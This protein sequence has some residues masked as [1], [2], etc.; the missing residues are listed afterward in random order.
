MADKERLLQDFLELVQIDSPSGQ[1]RQIADV[2]KNKLAALGF[3]VE[4]DNAGGQIG[5]TAGNIIARLPGTGRGPM[6]MLSAHMD[7]VEPGR[8]VKPVIKD[9]VITSQGDTVL[10]GDDKGGIAV[11]LEAVRIIQEKNISHGGLEVIFTVWEEGGLKGSKALDYSKIKSKMG[12]VLDADGEPGYIITTAPTQ[13]TLRA[14]IKGKAAHA[15]MCP[16]KGINAIQVAS[17]AIAAMNIGRIDQ[18]TTANIGVIR[19]GKAINIVPE[20]T[21]IEGE[22]RS[23]QPEKLAAQVEHMCAVL[24]READAAGAQIEID[25]VKEYDAINLSAD[26]PI[27]GYCVTAAENLGFKPVLASSGGGSDANIF[28]GHGIACVNLGIGMNKVHTVE[29]SI[30]LNHLLK[31]ADFVAEIIAV[32]NK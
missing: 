1:E 16:E 23:L 18:E 29:E 12:L 14:T 20:D 10:G 11:I 8:G 7:T 15:G 9:G 31:A 25:V 21:Y 26:D 6:L 22:A 3:D 2:L 17:K 5:A 24:R 13:S 19:G 30:E 32:A 27:V 28:N 4:E